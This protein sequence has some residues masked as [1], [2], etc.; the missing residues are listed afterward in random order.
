MRN[1]VEDGV[2]VDEDLSKSEIEL[3]PMLELEPMEVAIM[4]YQLW[5]VRG[6]PYGSPEDDWYK[7]ERRIKAPPEP[8]RNGTRPRGN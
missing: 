2:T 3:D 1:R 4:A 5:E 8:E 6:C 7:A